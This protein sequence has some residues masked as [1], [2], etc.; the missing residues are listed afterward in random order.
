L[1]L[2]HGVAMTGKLPE[3]ITLDVWY[4]KC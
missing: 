4:G 2:G 1:V 3:V